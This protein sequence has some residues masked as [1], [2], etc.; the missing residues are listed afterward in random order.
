[1]LPL[2][3]FLQLFFLLFMQGSRMMSPP[4]PPPSVSVIENENEF[5]NMKNYKK[6][7]IENER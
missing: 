5:D 1:M 2:L 3:S 7:K 4:P 6:T